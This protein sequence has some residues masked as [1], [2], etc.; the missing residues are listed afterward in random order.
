LNGNIGEERAAERTEA[1]RQWDSA[2]PGW[3]RWEPAIGAWLQEATEIMVDL[4][5]VGPGSRVLDVACGAGDQSLAAARRTGP[6]GRVLATDISPVMVEFAAEQ[7]KAA[8]LTNLRAQAAAAEDVADVEGAPFDAAICR[9]ALMLL[10]DPR[11]ALAAVGRSPRQGGRIG[12]VVFGPAAANPFMAEPLAILRRHA[13]K[14]APAPG[15][16]GIFALADPATLEVLLREAGFAEV[17]V[18]TIEQPLAMRSAADAVRMIQDA[19]GVYRAVISDQPPAVREA[20][21]AEV[22]RALS[23]FEG[24]D[25]FRAPAMVHAVGGQKS[26]A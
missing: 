12:A 9:L 7:A 6:S 24:P 21:W 23:R 2:A 15:G 11:V 16:P 22:A 8:G 4:A 14:P 10:P 1:R 13:N 5:G 25:G 19:F 20:A 26:V 3:A 18:R 17:M